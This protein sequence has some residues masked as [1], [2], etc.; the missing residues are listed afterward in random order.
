MVWDTGIFIIY[1]SSD[2]MTVYRHNSHYRTA[3][4]VTTTST[5][6]SATTATTVL[7]L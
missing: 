3:S 4:S 5:A 2:V 1:L 6:T 7:Q